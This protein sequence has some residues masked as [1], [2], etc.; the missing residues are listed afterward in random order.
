MQAPILKHIKS[1]TTATS[2]SAATL[3]SAVFS[4][5]TATKSR[6]PAATKLI[7]FAVAHVGAAGLFFVC[8][9]DNRFREAQILTQISDSFVREVAVVVLP[10]GIVR[11]NNNPNETRD[12][13]NAGE[14]EQ[15]ETGR[16]D[17]RKMKSL[18]SPKGDS[19]ES[20]ALERFHEHENF[21]V[22]SSF[23]VR[24]RLRAR[25]LLDDENALLEEIAENSNAIFFWDKH[26]A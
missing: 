7:L 3:A 16:H 20:T 22:G 15:G 13:E 12:I 8:G 11:R 18:Y 21:E 1:D 5:T 24:V 10:A 26:G 25:V 23:D 2:N 17:R 6:T 9:R 14:E 19:N 4:I